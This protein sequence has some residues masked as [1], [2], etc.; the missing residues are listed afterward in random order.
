M[1]ELMLIVG[2]AAVVGCGGISKEKYGAKEAEAA[3]YKQALQDESGRASALDAQVKT[4][5]QQNESLKSQNA[6]LQSQNAKLQSQV[7]SM[8]SELEAT[9]SKLKE[10]SAAYEELKDRTIRINERLVFKENSSKLTPESKHSLDAIADAVAQ[11]KDKALLVAGYTDDAEG[12]G[13]DAK[14]KRWQLSTARALEVAKYLTSRG[15]DPAHIGVAGFGEG[16]PVVAND[17]LPNKA[18]NRRVEIALTPPDLELGTVDVS[19]ATVSPR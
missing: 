10:Q 13:K 6:A 14:V 19:P 9:A 5:E 2:I 18:Q 11:L 1:R 15:L 12:G 16:R 8:T 3:K 7:T 4:L 17:S